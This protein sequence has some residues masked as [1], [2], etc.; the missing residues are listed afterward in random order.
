[1]TCER[2]DERGHLL[3][4]LEAAEAALGV[5]H[6]GGA[7]PF[8]HRAVTPTLHVVSRVTR[9]R[10]HA[11]DAVRVRERRGEPPVD[12]EPPDGEHLLEAFAQARRRVGP[13]LLQLLGEVACGTLT[14]GCVLVRERGGELAVDPGLLVF[15]E[16][17]FD[18]AA[19]VELMPISA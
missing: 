3:V 14:V 6:P 16:V 2:G 5:E 8:D 18:V 19:L 9:D 13:P 11:L 4:A 17:V 1:M 15:G 12:P 10:D 7:P